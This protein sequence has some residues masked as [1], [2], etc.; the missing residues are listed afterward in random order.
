MY[1]LDRYEKM[2][3]ERVGLRGMIWIARAGALGFWI[4][5]AVAFLHLDYADRHLRT[6]GVVIVTIDFVLMGLSMWGV[7]Q[8]GM[9]RDYPDAYEAHANRGLAPARVHRGDR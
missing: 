9:I 1:Y 7:T 6:Y 4:A 8:L 3:I 5:N 2:I